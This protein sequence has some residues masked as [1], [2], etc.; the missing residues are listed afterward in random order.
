M[1][2]SGKFQSATLL[3]HDDADEVDKQV[4]LHIGLNRKGRGELLKHI[5]KRALWF[6]ALKRNAGD[7]DFLYWALTN[8][9][10]LLITRSA[11]STEVPTKR[12]L[13]IVNSKANDENM[14]LKQPCCK[15]LKSN[16]V[17]K[18]EDG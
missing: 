11:V 15:R 3:F 14:E 13:V 7:R 1:S 5:G 9:P 17:V 8:N 4:A 10:R 6:Q 18:L 16:N 2:Q 12:Y